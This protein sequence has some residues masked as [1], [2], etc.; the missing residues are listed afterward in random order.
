MNSLKNL[1]KR[2]ISSQLIPSWIPVLIFIS[3]LIGFGDATFF[4]IKHY[5]NVIPP[6]TIGGCES[7]L[8]SVYAEVF[9]VPVALFGSIYYLI[10]S[11]SL[12]IYFDT[13][14]EIYLR[15]PLLISFVGL[16]SSI[17]F[18]F[19]QIFVIKAFCPYCAVSALTSFTI[20]GFAVYL[21]RKSKD[22]DIDTNNVC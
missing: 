9:G 14:K 18:T 4:T 16:L 15:I 20:F 2:P 12:F 7:V 6:C 21:F 17:W 8:N 3:A 13:K 5:Q 1:L 10:I 19:L 11:L 22:T